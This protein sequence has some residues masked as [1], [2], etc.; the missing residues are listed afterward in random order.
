M[1]QVI[2]YTDGSSLGNPGAGG[3]A[4]LLMYNQQKKTIHGNAKKATNNQ[5]ELTAAIKSLETLKEPCLVELH[6]DSQYLKQGITNWIHNWKKNNWRSS[7]KT[8]VKNVELWQELDKLNK[9]HQVSWHWVKAHNGHEFNELV[10]KLAY[11]SAKKIK[12]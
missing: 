2:I 7:A 11:D 3:W 10:D 8:A 9:Y 12:F 5:M 4:A 6:T 1:K